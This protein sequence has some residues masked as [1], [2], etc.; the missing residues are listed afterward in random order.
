MICF[1]MKGIHNN[2]G[3]NFSYVHS[4]L[5]SLSCLNSSKQFLILNKNNPFLNTPQFLMTKAFYNLVNILNCGMEANSGDIVTL[6]KNAF[7]KNAL[8]IKSKN[9]LSNDPFHFLNYSLEFLH[10][11]NN[12][13][14]NGNYILNNLYNQNI[15]NQRDDDHMYCLFLGFFQQTQNSFIS[16]YFLNVEKY[17][18]NCMNC[19]LTYFYG[20][21]KIFRIKLDMVRYYRDLSFPMRRG[22]KLSLNECFLCY[23]G[24]NK[25]QCKICGN[26]NAFIYTKICCSAKVLMIYLERIK[27]C[28]YGDV[29]IENNFNIA[30]FYSISRTIGLNYNPTYVLKAC[31]SYCNTGKYFADCYVNTNNSLNSGWYRFMDNQIKFL[32]NPSKQINDY[33]PQLLIYELDDSFYKNSYLFN[34][35]FNMNVNNN[36]MDIF[37]MNI[38]RII[39]NI[40]FIKY[41]NMM[42]FQQ[43]NQTVDLAQ[44]QNENIMKYIAFNNQADY[45]DIEYNKLNNPFKQEVYNFQLHFIIVPEEGDQSFEKNIKIMAQVRSNFTVEQAIDNFFKKALKKREAIKRFIL[46]GDQLDSK[47]QQTLDSLNI[48]EDTIIKAIKA[49]NFDNL[50]ISQ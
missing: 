4:V 10:L 8:N 5:Q 44:K 37:V 34:N 15:E 40:K 18:Y 39:D 47:S 3:Y 9:V 49:E 24:G 13:P 11:E 7:L 12:M 33:E 29:E 17:T 16:K 36:N 43:T 45:E 20:I 48:N 35:I 2:S 25:I 31:I 46:D 14:L 1:P 23:C 28:F 19:G 32:S 41:K 50:N 27:H 26:K 22:A 38:Q 21:N 6:F 42:V 30:N